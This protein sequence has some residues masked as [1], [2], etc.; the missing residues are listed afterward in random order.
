MRLYYFPRRRRASHH[1]YKGQGLDSISAWI[2]VSS[3]PF[4]GPQ[5]DFAVNIVPFLPT[6]FFFFVIS[7]STEFITSL[8]DGPSVTSSVPSYTSE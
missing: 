7:L 8:V 5:K 1:L 3:Q 4:S 6:F 2:P